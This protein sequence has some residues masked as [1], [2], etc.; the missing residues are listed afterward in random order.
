MRRGK[1]SRRYAGKPY[2]RRGRNFRQ[3]LTILVLALAV[4]S[5]IFLTYAKYARKERL[6]GPEDQ[7]NAD[8][9]GADAAEIAE[10]PQE[11]PSRGEKPEIPAAGDTLAEAESKTA[12]QDDAADD[13]VQTGETSAVGCDVMVPASEAVDLSYFDDAVFIGD[14]RTEGLFINTGL[15]NATFLTHQGLTVDEVFTKEVVTFN[16]KKTTVMD[17]LAQTSFRKVYI[18]LGINETGW[19]YDDIFIEK[20]GEII[21]GIRGINPDAVIY[22]QSILPVSNQVS[23]T[24]SYIK[25]EKINTYNQLLQQMAEEKGVY[26][27]DVAQAVADSDGSLPT[28]ASA[29]GIHLKKEPCQAWLTYLREH[30]VQGPDP[31][32]EKGT[33]ES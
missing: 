25:N 33:V 26:Y 9:D 20:Y 10:V 2:Y 31:S 22:V 17:A 21:D 15:S 11:N 14:S 27:L 8:V 19:V 24:H 3:F 6:T 32:P 18:M 1:T 23:A 30:T 29:D 5:A 28:D 7:Q 12:E 4:S 16:G 13:T